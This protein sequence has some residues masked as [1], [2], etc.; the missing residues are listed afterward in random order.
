MG[1]W[2]RHP[3][4]DWAVAGARAIGWIVR[5][6]C[7]LSANEDDRRKEISCYLQF[8]VKNWSLPA[9]DNLLYICYNLRSPFDPPAAL[10]SHPP[11]SSA[12]PNSTHKLRRYKG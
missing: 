7:C 3:F 9:L 12:G 2:L 8:G 11:S 4:F 10:S 5:V 1:R 6:A